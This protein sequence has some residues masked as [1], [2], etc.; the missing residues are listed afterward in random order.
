MNGYHR[1]NQNQQKYSDKGVHIQWM[2]TEY[3]H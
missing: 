3:L 2:R 1:K